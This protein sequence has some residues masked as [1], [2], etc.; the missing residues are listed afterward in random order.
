MKKTKRVILIFILMF[1]FTQV[2]FA[3]DNEEEKFFVA[4]KAFSDGFYE[5][6]F[7]LFK[8][9]TEDFPGSKDVY[10]AKLYMAKC[11]YY[12]GDYS[13]A[14][15]ILNELL[16]KTETAQVYDEINY[17]LAQVYLRGKNFSNS[18]VC[19]KK[20]IS[21]YPQSKFL[22]QAYY[23]AGLNSL[24]LG[25]VPAAQDYLEQTISQSKRIILLMTRIPASLIFIFS[26]KTIHVLFPLEKNTKNF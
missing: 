24:E 20:I 18:L 15:P 3:L 8:K 7:S 26:K 17:L 13:A 21:D 16:S 4:S 10:S 19:A 22:W 5:A 23:L 14:L 2:I 1:S 11:L 6:S 9:F 25:D 12:K